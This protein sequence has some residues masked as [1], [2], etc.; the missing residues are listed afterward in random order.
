MENEESNSISINANSSANAGNSNT[1]EKGVVSDNY[2]NESTTP[3]QD[4]GKVFVDEKG[5]LFGDTELNK[6]LE[7]QARDEENK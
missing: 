5:P 6:G 7:S 1:D 3:Q 4:K 2:L